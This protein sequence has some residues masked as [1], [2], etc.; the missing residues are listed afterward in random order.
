MY[1]GADYTVVAWRV[2]YYVGH[3]IRGTKPAD[4]TVEQPREFDVEGPEWPSAWRNAGGSV[5]RIVNSPIRS[6]DHR[7]SII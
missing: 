1:Y 2:A 7:T 6:P 5:V 4:L 3:L